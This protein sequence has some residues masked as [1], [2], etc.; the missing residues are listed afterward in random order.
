MAIM[1]DKSQGSVLPE[2]VFTGW[3]EM[4]HERERK[5]NITQNVQLLFV[6]QYT[7]IESSNHLPSPNNVTEN[8]L[9]GLWLNVLMAT[10]WS[11]D[12]GTEEKLSPYI[13]A[14][15]HTCI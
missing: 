12:T 4:E 11:T 1:T 3:E 8:A 2:M 10:N 6:K 5:E 14:E 13:T 7:C 9:F 15:M